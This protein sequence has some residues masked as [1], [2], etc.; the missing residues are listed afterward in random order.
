M[1]VKGHVMGTVFVSKRRYSVA[2]YSNDHPP[3][4][5]HVRA[6]GRDARFLL[7]CPHGPVE[8]WDYEGKWTLRQVN[9]LGGEISERLEDC[10]RM[11]SSNHG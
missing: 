9:E 4:H 8:L 1:P 5:V 6:A 3:P 11:W 2:I 7:N 10:C